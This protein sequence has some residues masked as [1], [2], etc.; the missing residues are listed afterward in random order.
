MLH[1]LSQRLAFLA[2]GWI[3]LGAVA[4]FVLFSV[5]VLPIMAAQSKA[6]LCGAAQPDTSLIYSP[7]DLYRMAEAFGPAGRQAYIQARLTF[8]VAFPVV[9]GLVLIATI[10]WLAGRAFP[11]GSPWR[12]VNL[13]PALGM[14]FDYLENSAA[15]IVMTRYPLR[16]PGVDILAPVFTFVKWIFAG[17]SFV[18][19]LALIAAAGWRWIARRRPTL[20]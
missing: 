5:L 20:K 13:A 7:A 19:L 4:V 6:R 11:A 15:V 2:T 8:D 14:L 12:L 10:S 18:V 9:Y 3:V 16:T 17:G 1:R